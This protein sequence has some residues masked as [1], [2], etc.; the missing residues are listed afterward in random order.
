MREA[1]PVG[2]DFAKSSVVLSRPR[3]AGLVAVLRVRLRHLD[4]EQGVQMR[5]VPPALRT[6]EVRVPP[7][8]LVVMNRL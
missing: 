7:G 2:A 1:H 3:S 5:T 4:L 6:S 8:N